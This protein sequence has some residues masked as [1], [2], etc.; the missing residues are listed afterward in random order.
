MTLILS[1]DPAQTTGYA[2]YD[3]QAPL[4][5]IEAGTIK[6]IGESYE[7]KAA[8]LGRSL[9]KIIKAKRPDFIAIEM[10]IRTQPGQQKRNVKFMGEEQQ[11]ESSGSG[12]NAV[13]SSNQLVGA[14]SAIVGAYNIEFVTIAPVTWRKSFLGFGTHKGWTRQDW[15]KAVRDRCASLRIVVTNSDQADAVG[16]AFA[17]SHH[18]AVRALKAKV[19]A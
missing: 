10:P 18:A 8:S 4:A 12:L 13:I 17:A 5:A 14:I 19:A 16:I 2:Y 6:C 1:F 11:I 3:D 7:D 9:V 15:K